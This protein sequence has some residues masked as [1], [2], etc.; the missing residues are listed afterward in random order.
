MKMKIL[1]LLIIAIATV[2]LSCT[3]QKGKVVFKNRSVRNKTL[4]VVWDGSVIKSLYP[5]EDSDTIK[6]EPGSH[7]L[8]FKEANTNI[9]ACDKG[10]P[11]ITE[12]YVTTFTCSY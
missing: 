12:G 4:N 10:N 8:V 3:K 5:Q 7:T 6:V 1:I 9:S 11:S 2:Q